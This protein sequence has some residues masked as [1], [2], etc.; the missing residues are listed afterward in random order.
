MSIRATRPEDRDGR[1]IDLTNPDEIDVVDDVPRRRRAFTRSEAIEGL[2]ALLASLAFVE[3]LRVVFQQRSLVGAVIW[4]F[5]GFLA[6]YALLVRD[7]ADTET[8][9]D[10][11]VTVAIWTTGALVVAALA[12]MLIYLVSKGLPA[13]RPSFFTQDLSKV[14]PLNPGGGAKHAIIGTFEQVAI[15]TVIV[16]PIAVL[17]A[18]YLNEIKGRLALPV[19]IIVDA[20]SGMPS[21]VAGLL[22]FT[23][24][25][26][27][28]GFSG[29]AGSGALVVLMLPTVTRT[30]EEILRTIP[31]QLREGGLALGAPQWRLVMRVVVP[32]ALAGLMTAVILGIARAIGETAPMILTAF[33]ADTTNVNP[34]HGP[35]GDL[36][37]FVLKLIRVPNATQNQRAWTG[38]LILV[39]LVLVLFVAARLVTSRSQRKLG[40]AR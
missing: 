3:V 8:A 36:P 15:A 28:H 4:T 2:V 7:R 27:G 12:W 19:R 17:T 10:R 14:G 32:T 18:I 16:V 20:M 31:D 29:I 25:V 21:I 5:F 33:G 35:Q 37:L 26:D 34:T 30:S 6:V 40:R 38:A 24:W 9:V 23:V 22:V 1:V 39:M 13:L 11:V